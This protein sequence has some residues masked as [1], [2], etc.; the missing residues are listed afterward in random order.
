MTFSQR[1][2][3]LKPDMYLRREGSFGHGLL[4][5]SA[6]GKTMTWSW[7]RNQDGIAVTTDSTTLVRDT[8]ACPTR[9]AQASH[10]LVLAVYTTPPL[11][12]PVEGSAE[13]LH[14]CKRLHGRVLGKLG[15]EAGTGNATLACHVAHAAH[16]SA[17]RL[18][19]HSIWSSAVS[20]A[21]E[22]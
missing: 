7:N 10:P 18:V 11:P 17:C 16:A 22:R 8:T 12:C 15:S 5:I 20:A 13:R 14:I 21:H 3:A 4:N 2:I 9:G 1:S 6:D 19:Q